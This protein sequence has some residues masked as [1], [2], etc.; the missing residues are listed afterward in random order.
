MADSIYIYGTPGSVG[1]ASTKLAHLLKL[2]RDI[3]QITLV[4]P[5][6]AT[7]KARDVQRYCVGTPCMLLK[8]L[9]DRL[10]GTVLAVCERTFFSGGIARLLKAKGLRVIWS[11][12]M[13]FPF[14]G[15]EDAVRA[16]LVDKVL[17]A[18]EFQAN[19]FR[20]TYSGIPF[21]ITGNYIDGDDY[22]YHDRPQRAFTIGRLSR[23]DV[24]K[25]P[26]NFPVFYERLGLRD[27]RYRVMAWSQELQNQYRWHRFGPE[28]D[29][30][31]VRKETVPQFLA[32]LE[33]FL[34]PLGHRVKESWG[35]AVVEAMLSGCVVVVPQGHQFENLVVHGETGF[36]CR[37][38]SEFRSTVRELFEN[39]SVLRALGRAA[40]YRAR[41][42]L[43]N[44]VEHQRV[45]RQALSL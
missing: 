1:G 13:M 38:Y 39:Y 15:E 19:A 35:R 30:L 18:S 17:F 20:D 29:L 10:E 26:C 43:C 34:Y 44:A 7:L 36:V 9:P 25:Y 32:S 28:W 3:Y 2:L 12:E 23:A 40:S 5:N 6:V 21:L 4:L 24:S 8:E 14:E 16:G 11:N 37:N 27:A 42:S 33:V 31:P 41:T 45:W 22:P